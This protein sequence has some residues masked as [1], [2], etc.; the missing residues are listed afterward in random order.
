MGIKA[1]VARAAGAPLEEFEYEPKPLGDLDVEIQVA[2]CGICHSDL[3]LW[4]NEWGFTR[5]PFVPGHEIV[6]EVTELGAF[7][8]HLKIGQR[9]GVGWLAGSCGSCEWCRGGEEQFCPKGQPTC[10]GRNGGFAESVRVNSRFAL[11]LPDGLESRAAAPLMCGGITVF[12][13]LINN[14]VRPTMHVGV[15]GIGGLGH[16]AIQFAR[17]FGCEVTAFSTT[18]EKQAE[19]EKFGAHHFVATG[20]PN[21]LRKVANRFDLI[22]STVA[23]DLPWADYIAA[24]RPKGRFVFVGVPD[25]EIHFPGLPLLSGGKSVVSSPTGSTLGIEAMLRFAART[26]VAAQTESFPMSQANDALARLAAN[27]ARYRI[28]LE[29]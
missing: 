3:S 15:V 18:P 17:A 2:H 11:A 29:N 28:V 13:P 12:S 24:L 23:A 20:V 1:L 10:V 9:V 27:E 6:G 22:L 14:D 26:G 8:R 19:A 7:V 4:R 25:G 21:A 5:F 16:L